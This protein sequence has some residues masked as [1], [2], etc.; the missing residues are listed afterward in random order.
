M[1][2]HVHVLMT[3]RDANPILRCGEE[4]EFGRATTRTCTDGRCA[5]PSTRSR[6][7]TPAE[8]SSLNRVVV[9]QAVSHSENRAQEPR[10]NVNGGKSRCF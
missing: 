9:E 8:L 10:V 4:V 3:G 5:D 1:K 6:T 7:I 2:D